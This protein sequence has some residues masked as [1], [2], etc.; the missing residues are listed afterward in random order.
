MIKIVCFMN[1]KSGMSMDEF[2]TYY[3]EN[4]VPLINKL[5][6]F[7]QDYRRNFVE[8]REHSAAHMAPGR[9]QEAMFDV[10]TELTFE[11]EEMHQKCL[12]AL[13]DPV[14]GKIV[15]DDEAKFF[16]RASMRTFVVD[17][18]RSHR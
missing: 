10:M 8:D 5:M 1:R 11:N 12:E 15:A 13:A 6:P 7:W 9:S 16:D 2:K 14:I 17:E 3:E 18:R 4:H